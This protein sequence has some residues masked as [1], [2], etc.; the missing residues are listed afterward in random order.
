MTTVTPQFASPV[1][2]EA[3]GGYGPKGMGGADRTFVR[4]RYP[5]QG[6]DV[7]SPTTGCR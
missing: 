1:D 3:C 5:F 2:Y 6:R 4:P 7:P